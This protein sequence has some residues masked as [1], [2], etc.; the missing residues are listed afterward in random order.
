MD[1][2]FK[3]T[4]TGGCPECMAFGRRWYIKDRFVSENVYEYCLMSVDTGSQITYK[5][6]S[7]R[8]LTEWICGVKDLS[9]ETEHFIKNWYLKRYVKFE[10]TDAALLKK[11]G[12]EYRLDK[13]AFTLS[14]LH[15]CIQETGWH[16]SYRDCLETS[17]G[18]LR[19]MEKEQ[20]GKQIA[21]V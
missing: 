13:K 15:E 7:L 11:D 19:R 9:K 21:L 1:F 17:K 4:F 5:F 3:S 20:S 16:S 12:I 6:N 14:Q 18:I 8:E 10:T 2:V